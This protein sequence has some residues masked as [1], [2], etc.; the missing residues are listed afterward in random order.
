MNI[1][2]AVKKC[3]LD[4]VEAGVPCDV[5]FGEVIGEE[6]VRVR[7]GELTIEDELLTVCE[8]LY[9]KEATFSFSVYERTI[10]INEGLKTGDSVVLLRKKGGEGYVVVGKV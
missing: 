3:A 8:H 4:A 6:P 9:Y 2:E 10:V 7:A 5:I 1:A